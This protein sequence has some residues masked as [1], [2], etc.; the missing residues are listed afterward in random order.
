M[1]KIPEVTVLIDLGPPNS[2]PEM[3]RRIKRIA[4]AI[5]ASK[6]NSVTEKPKLFVLILMRTP[7]EAVVI[8]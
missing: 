8:A 5:R 4:M 6:Q 2:P 3:D 1:T 7:R